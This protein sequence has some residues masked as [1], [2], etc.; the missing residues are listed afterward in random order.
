VAWLGSAI[1]TRDM[2]AM[3]DDAGVRITH[4]DPFVRWDDQWQ[5]DLP[6]KDFPKNAIAF[7]ADETL[8]RMDASG[9]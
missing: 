5:P 2:K 1:S 3:A 8:A 9:I 6:G 4:L 7:D